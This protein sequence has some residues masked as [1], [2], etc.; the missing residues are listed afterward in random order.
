MKEDWLK[1]ID[2]ADIYRQVCLWRMRGK[3]YVVTFDSGAHWSVSE[4]HI[5]DSSSERLCFSIEVEEIK[6]IISN[7]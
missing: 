7:N 4:A 3:V 6:E 5:D 1:S 2:W